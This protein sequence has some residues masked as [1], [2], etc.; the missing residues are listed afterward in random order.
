M[1]PSSIVLLEIRLSSA[2]TRTPRV[3]FDSRLSEISFP[4]QSTA[5]PWGQ[6]EMLL[7]YALID[8]PR[9]TLIPDPMAPV[10][11]LLSTR[12]PVVND[13]PPNDTPLMPPSIVLPQIVTP[14][15]PSMNIPASR[16]PA[17]NVLLVTFT[18]PSGQS[19][20]CTPASM[21]SLKRESLTVT[22][23]DPTTV[24]PLTLESPR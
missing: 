18:L 17:V 9:D 4:F 20:R 2:W 22:L 3:L 1:L 12:S 11:V 5:I 13:D 24:I 6:P 19:T 14:W 21:L 16:P 7:P 15:H 10:M 23:R 8:V